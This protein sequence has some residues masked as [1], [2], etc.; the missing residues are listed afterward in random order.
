MTSDDLDR[1]KRIYKHGYI[2]SIC[3]ARIYANASNSLRYGSHSVTCKR[4]HI[5]LYL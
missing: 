4:Y 2:T 3:I 5:C 1:P